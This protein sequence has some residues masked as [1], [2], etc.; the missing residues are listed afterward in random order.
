VTLIVPDPDGGPDV[1]LFDDELSKRLLGHENK[2]A[3]A[4]VSRTT[5]LPPGLDALRIVPQLVAD[6]EF[7]LE[8]RREAIEW[9]RR[10]GVPITVSPTTAHQN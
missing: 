4:F 1:H 9:L 2:F 8:A 7:P 5:P 10:Q 3:V 6:P